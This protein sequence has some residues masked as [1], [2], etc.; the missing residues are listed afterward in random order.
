MKSPGRPC[1]GRV[2][3]RVRALRGAVVRRRRVKVVDTVQRL[4]REPPTVTPLDNLSR[5]VLAENRAERDLAA[6]RRAAADI[7][8]EHK[9]FRPWRRSRRRSVNIPYRGRAG[10]CAREVDIAVRRGQGRR[11]LDGPPGKRR[12]R[13][14]EHRANDSPV[15][16]GVRRRGTSAGQRAGTGQSLPVNTYRKANEQEAKRETRERKE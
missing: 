10:R 12:R 13:Q 9:G 5:A 2:R 7:D 3:R 14:R 6:A 8:V 15:D 11:I 1:H 4:T 16:G